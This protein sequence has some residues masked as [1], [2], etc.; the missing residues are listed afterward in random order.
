MDESSLDVVFWFCI[1]ARLQSGRKEL[2]KNWA[3][4]PAIAHPAKKSPGAKAQIF[5]AFSTARL[6]S[7]PDTKHQSGD[8][9]ENSRIP[10]IPISPR[11]WISAR[12]YVVAKMEDTDHRHW[13]T[14]EWLLRPAGRLAGWLPSLELH[15]SPAAG[16]YLR[17]SARRAGRRWPPS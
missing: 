8:C 2:K 13:L 5:V 9:Q 14:G 11:V 10:Q 7:C 16:V 6:K 3:S 12:T 17:R 4:A 15:W 1:R